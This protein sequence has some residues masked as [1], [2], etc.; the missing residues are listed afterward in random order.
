M[1]VLCCFSWDSIW[2]CLFFHFEP[3]KPSI[4]P[5][6]WLLRQWNP[7]QMLQFVHNFH[8]IYLML[9]SSVSFECWQTNCLYKSHSVSQCIMDFHDGFSNIN[10]SFSFFPT[11]FNQMLFLVAYDS[12]ETGTIWHYFVPKNGRETFYM[13]LILVSIWHRNAM[14]L[15]ENFPGTR[16]S[17]IYQ[18]CHFTSFRLSMIKTFLWASSS[19]CVHNIIWYAINLNMVD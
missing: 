9:P 19:P 10:Y 11:P 17:I 1:N 14:M 15:L 13:N 4:I 8:S 12:A 7:S 3:L 2:D 18:L 5:L 6:V 16:I